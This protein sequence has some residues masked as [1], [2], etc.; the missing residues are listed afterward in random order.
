MRKEGVVVWS[1]RGNASEVIIR[2]TVKRS[3]GIESRLVLD[4]CLTISVQY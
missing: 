2:R 4:L 1:C 3:F